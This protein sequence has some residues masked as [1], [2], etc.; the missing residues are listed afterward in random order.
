[1]DGTSTLRNANATDQF[2][3][4]VQQPTVAVV[5][6][7]VLVIAITTRLTSGTHE[8][9]DNGSRVPPTPGY[10][11]PYFGHV[12]QLAWNMDGFLASLRD[13]Y[14]KGVF[15]LRLLG[16]VHTVVHRPGL[17]TRLMDKP[18]SEADEK[19]LPAYLMVSNFGLS[20]SDLSLYWKMHDDVESEYKHLVAQDSLR[21]LVDTAARHLKESLPDWITFNS[22][23][24]DQMEWERQAE[25]DRIDA[26]SGETFVE[27]DLV[28]LTR[29]FVARTTV[30]ALMG[31]DFAT[32]FSEFPKLLWGFDAAFNMLAMKISPMWI[33]WPSVQR[34][35]IARKLALSHLYEFH[36]ALDKHL[37]DEDPGA[38]WQDMH[39]VSALIQ[40]RASVYRKHQI[41][42]SIRAAMDFSLLWD[43]NANANPLVFW[44]LLEISR[45]LILLEQIRDEIS[46]YVRAVQPKNEFGMGVWISPTLETLDVDGLV[47]GCPLLKAAYAET[48]RL[49]TG[50]WSWKW[51]QEDSVLDG[52]GQV[53]GA[54]LLRKGTYAYVPHELHQLDPKCFPNPGEWQPMR[55]V[56][57]TLGKDGKTIRTTKGAEN[58]TPYGKLPTG[59]WELRTFGRCVLIRMQV[60]AK[61]WARAAPLHYENYSCTRRLS[62]PCTRFG[63]RRARNGRC[64]RR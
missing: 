35:R 18:Q 41:P 15:S 10:W 52:D 25:A 26:P 4:R 6:L 57:E 54:Y 31:T 28:E 30:A 59:S 11:L 12:P 50:A 8:T 64:L 16:K 9:E 32:N 3:A 5:I 34:A 7:T 44:M 53:G 58:I 62:W 60:T 20:K 51:M 23:P 19:W 22:Y 42:L 63:R 24:A 36:E 2:A 40:A 48:T 17:I 55:H 1:M 21:E 14:P 39:N 38:R 13:N 27:A 46:P 29:N 47:N 61:L 56:E 49:Y 43:V 33:P 37:A 45:D